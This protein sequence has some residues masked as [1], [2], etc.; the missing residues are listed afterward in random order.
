M[1]PSPKTVVAI[2]EALWDLFP[3]GRRP[4][5]APCNVA[6]H[7]TRLGDRGVIVT[8]LGSDA[9]GDDLLAF[10]GERE[11]VTAHVQRDDEKPTG[12][13]AVTIENSD[14]RFTIAEDV[15]WDY[16]AADEDARDLVRT[17]DAVCVGSLAQRREPSRSAIRLLLSEARG[18]A[19]VVFDVNLRP[20]FIE[21]DVIETTLHAADV[22]KMNER[23]VARISATLDRPSL[24]A[25]LLEEVGIRTVCVTRGTEG[26]SIMTAA[27]TVSAPGIAI[28]A[29]GG[30]SVGAGDAFTAAIAHLLARDLPPAEALQAANRYAALVASKRGA[31]PTI[32]SEELA[33]IGW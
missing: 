33:S 23:E 10:L 7:A 2:G 18:R 12:T 29:S 5:G 24:A 16:L 8:R 30:D 20:P 1:S 6:Y 19:L 3:D 14:P 31:M 32:S 27:G 28:D 11:V 25:W 4:G 17:A 13:V 26:A 21:T 15:A 22:V 9:A